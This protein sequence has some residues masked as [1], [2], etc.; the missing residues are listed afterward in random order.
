MPFLPRSID[1]DYRG[2]KIALWIFGVLLLSKLGVALG[3]LFNGRNAAMSADGI[4]I[5]RY[6][7]AGATVIV[8]MFAAWGLAQT[9]IVAMG[10]VVL[11]RYRSAVPFFFG[12]LLFEHAARKLIFVLI[13]IERIGT[14]PGFY[15]NAAMFAVEILGLTLALWRRAPAGVTSASAVES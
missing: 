2:A 14:P 7:P 12:L 5:D 3:C 8:A 15:V 13:P 11:V 10:I 4:P 6:T 1:N 9:L